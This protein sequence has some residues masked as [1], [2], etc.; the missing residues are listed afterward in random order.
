MNTEIKEVIQLF[1]FKHTSKC[2]AALLRN[3]IATAC[4]PTRLVTWYSRTN[5]NVIKSDVSDVIRA[6]WPGLGSPSQH[7]LMATL[8]W[9]RCHDLQARKERIKHV[10]WQRIREWKEVFTWVHCNA[11]CGKNKQAAIQALKVGQCCPP[12]ITVCF[13]YFIFQ[14]YSK[15][16]ISKKKKHHAIV[17][18]C[19]AEEHTGT[20]SRHT[21]TCP[22]VYFLSPCVFS[23][24]HITTMNSQLAQSTA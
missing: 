21:E 24:L 6:Q 17:E 10:H 23:A 22:C 9:L 11:P 15:V 4:F 5:G 12:C 20:R 2:S 8:P 16:V 3:W 7:F 19:S 1:L 13:L 18:M 14:V